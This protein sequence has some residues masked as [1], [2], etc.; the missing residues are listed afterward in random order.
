MWIFD[1]NFINY[2]NF[3]LQSRFILRGAKKQKATER[4]R[5]PFVFFIAGTKQASLLSTD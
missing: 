3:L 1:S 2:T 5:L 4:T